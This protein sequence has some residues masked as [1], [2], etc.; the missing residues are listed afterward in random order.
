MLSDR[1]EADVLPNGLRLPWF[2][3]DHNSPRENHKNDIPLTP[4]L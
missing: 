4:S 3:L 1:P 2:G